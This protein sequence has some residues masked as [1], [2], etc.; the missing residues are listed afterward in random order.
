M[1]KIETHLITA[2]VADGGKYLVPKDLPEKYE[3]LIGKPVKLTYFTGDFIPE[4]EE[5][6]VEK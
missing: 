2:V 1:R 5:R 6:E 4:F 3:A